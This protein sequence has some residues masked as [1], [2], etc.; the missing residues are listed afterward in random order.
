M[1][2][3]A[4]IFTIQ[5]F[6]GLC[7][8]LRQSDNRLR[9]SKSCNEKFTLTSNKNLKHLPTGKC[10]IP[11]SLNDNSGIKLTSDCNNV[12]TQFKQTSFLSVKHLQTGKCI[13]PRGGYLFPEVNTNIVIYAG[14]DVNRLQFKFISGKLFHTCCFI[15]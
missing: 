8:S 13:H 1:T 14:C 15:Y 4:G 10:V 2:A 3:P 12:G 9:L 6:S 7:V 5:H 11:E